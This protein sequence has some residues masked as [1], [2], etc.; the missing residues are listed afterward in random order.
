MVS[1]NG[2]IVCALADAQLTMQP[3]KGNKPAPGADVEGIQKTASI[4]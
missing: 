1:L 3:P 2:A 4:G